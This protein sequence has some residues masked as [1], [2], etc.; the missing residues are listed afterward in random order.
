M[1]PL[2]G[3][4]PKKVF[5]AGYGTKLKE[6]LQ[7]QEDWLLKQARGAKPVLEPNKPRTRVELNFLAQI[8]LD[9]P[10]RRRC[11]WCW[12]VYQGESNAMWSLYGSKGV[13]LVST[14]GQV[15]AAIENAGPFRCLIASVLGRFGISQ[16]NHL[17]EV[18]TPP[19]QNRDI[20]GQIL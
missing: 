2:E 20:F 14:V 17:G 6:I 15:K 7:A 10:A 8:W 5:E 18:P 19:T 11:V 1:D 13:A 3:R 4:L 9:E 12:N 16:A